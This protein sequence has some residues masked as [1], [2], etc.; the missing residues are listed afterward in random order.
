MGRLHNVT[1]SVAAAEP[2]SERLS[3]DERREA[4]LAKAAELVAANAADLSMEAVAE[5]AGVSRPLLYKH[6]ANRHELLV[7]VHRRE[8]AL[9]HRELS[10]AV[11]S[12][13]GID[14]K[15]R[16]LIHGM[17][18]AQRSRGA[19]LSALRA[20]GARTSEFQ[21]EQAERDRGTVRYFT[22][23][24]VRQLGTDEKATR[25]IVSILL[26]SGE[27]VLA[28]W[29]LRPTPQHATQLEDAYV[30]ICMGALERLAHSC[31]V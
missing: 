9:L 15:F 3:R 19:A 20:A 8:A 18:K 10:D 13:H 1:V 6:F 4:L 29:R 22:R 14:E 2:G 5:A 23:V 30:N 26:R 21:A 17:L 28:E 31:Q 25:K 27:S 7:A 24:A 12:V 16:S 11:V